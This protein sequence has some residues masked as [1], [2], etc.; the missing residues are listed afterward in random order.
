MSCLDSDTLDDLKEQLDAELDR[1]ILL[2]S[3]YVSCIRESVKAKGVCASDLS[4]DLLTISAFNHTKKQ[5]MLLSAHETE[6]EDAADVNKIFNILAK[7]YAS[8]VNY[9]IFRVIANKYEVDHSQEELKY[10]DHLKDYLERHKVSEFIEINPLLKKYTATS[11]KLTL[12]IDI[13]ST[14]RLAKL[15]RLKAVFA[16]IIGVKSAAMQ[17]LDIKS[18]CVIVAYL[19]P[20]PVAELIFNKYTIFTEEQEVQMQ[21]LSVLWLECNDCRFDFTA[22]TDR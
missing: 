12:K 9:G 11:T 8:F 2:Y 18:G 13:E 21:N 3:S 15:E 10:P 5:R 4:S 19:I 7:E 20:T 16:K 14:A 22:K 6:L 17:L 1:I